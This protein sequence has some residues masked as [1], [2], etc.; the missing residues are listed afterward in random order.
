V[1]GENKTHFLKS[2]PQMIKDME[3]AGSP[4]SLEPRCD[5]AH[6]KFEVKGVSD[7]E[8]RFA[9]LEKKLNA[10]IRHFNIPYKEILIVDN[11]E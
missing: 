9:R 2:V 6:C 8:L 7:E 1:P 4:K 10:I 5:C 3:E 11:I